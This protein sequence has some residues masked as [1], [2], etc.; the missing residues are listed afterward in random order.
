MFGIIKKL[1]FFILFLLLIA[2]TAL[3]IINYRSYNKTFLVSNNFG[4][5]EIRRDD[6]GIPHVKGNT[7]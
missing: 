1:S 4:D 5:I 6:F 7:L 2:V 3:F